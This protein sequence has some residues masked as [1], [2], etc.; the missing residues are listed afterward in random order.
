MGKEREGELLCESAVYGREENSGSG[1]P[2]AVG[3]WQAIHITFGLPHLKLLAAHH[4]KM[5]EG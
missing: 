4:Q 5:P 3:G 2:Y 1:R